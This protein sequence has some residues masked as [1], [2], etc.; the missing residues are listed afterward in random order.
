MDIKCAKCGEP[1]DGYGVRNGD[2]D[3]DEARKFLRGQ[4]CPS[5]KFGTACPSCDGSG[6]DKENSGFHTDECPVCRGARTVS[7]RQ[8]LTPPSGWRYDW[9]PHTKPVP[10][11]VTV[12][13]EDRRYF[14]CLEGRAVETRVSCWACFETAPPCQECKGDGKLHR[15]DRDKSEAFEILSDLLAGD[16]D[17]LQCELEDLSDL[18]D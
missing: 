14:A 8:C 3:P 2:M 6:K 17:G 18:S 13:Q 4:G 15:G 10:D 11:S 5:C 16:E 7:V 1:W 9:D 12:P